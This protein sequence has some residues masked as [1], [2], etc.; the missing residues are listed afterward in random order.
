[1]KEF[2]FMVCCLHLGMV[3]KTHEPKVIFDEQ[4]TLIVAHR[5]L[6]CLD[7]ENTLSALTAAFEVGAD[8]VEFDVQLSKDLVPM[9][10]HDRELLR[11]TGID[12]NIDDVSYEELKKLQQKSE[13]YEMSYPIATLQ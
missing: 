13:R 11:L 3:T 7:L 5:G 6:T 12:K 10:F 8:G 4:R 9:V 2:F 1:M